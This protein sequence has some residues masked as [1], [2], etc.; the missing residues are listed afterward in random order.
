MWRPASA[1]EPAARSAGEPRA[2]PDVPVAAR[3]GLTR[4]DLLAHQG[5]RDLLG[6]RDH[7]DHRVHA[8]RQG[9][10]D[11]RQARRACRP[12]AVVRPA[13]P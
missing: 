10:P 5:L 3:L 6:L 12:V 1:G 8:A 11:H 4:P 2:E 13:V 9:R 7:P